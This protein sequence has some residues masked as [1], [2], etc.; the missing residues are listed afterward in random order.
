MN[1][2]LNEVPQKEEKLF[3]IFVLNIELFQRIV[4]LKIFLIVSSFSL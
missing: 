3:E 4:S 2:V 1:A